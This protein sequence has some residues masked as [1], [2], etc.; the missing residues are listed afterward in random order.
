MHEHER[1]RAMGDAMVSLHNRVEELR[2]NLHLTDMD[3]LWVVTQLAVGRIGVM[4][5]SEIMNRASEKAN[6]ILNSGDGS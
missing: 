1:H 6:E 4:R 5:D 3:M 2:R